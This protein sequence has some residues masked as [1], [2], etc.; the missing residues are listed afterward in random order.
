MWNKDATKLAF[1]SEQPEKKAFRVFFD[2]EAEPESEE[3][4]KELAKLDGE[5][6]KYDF[7][8][9]FGETLEGKKRPVLT[10]YDLSEKK[11]HRINMK[12]LG[13][14]ELYPSSPIFDQDDNVVFHAYHL[15]IAKLGLN[16]CFNRPTSVYR[17]S[18]W[19]NQKK[20]AS[21]EEKK[22]TSE[23]EKKESEEEKECLLECLSGD[24]YVACF[25]KFTDDFS[26]L[27]YSGSTTKFTTHTTCFEIK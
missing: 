22:E 14:E 9:S 1:I 8:Q 24:D 3:K 12:K 20:E 15:P 18:D 25:P 27:I 26:H 21:E 11:L 13:K 4:K 5:E 17:V 19:K 16:F 10:I 7:D 2:T 23:E 6:V